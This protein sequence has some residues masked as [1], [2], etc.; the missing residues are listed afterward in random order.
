[1]KIFLD[2][3][4][5]EEAEELYNTGVCDGI[6]MNPSLV[7]KVVDQNKKVKMEDYIKKILKLAKGTPVSLEVT[8]TDCKEMVRQGKNIFKIFN[9]TAR[10]VYVKIPINP[11]YGEE[12]G[13]ETDGIK[14]IRDLSKAGIPVNCTLIFTPEQALLAAK[15]GAAFVSPFAGRIDDFIK[16]NHDVSFEKTDYFPAFGWYESDK[17]WEDNGVVSGIDLVRQIV[18]IFR[19]HNIHTE[20]LAASMRNARQVREAALVGADI[21]T[22]PFKIFKN[23]L[24]HYKTREGMEKFTKDAPKEYNKLIS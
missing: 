24:E 13:K 3:A 19:Q 16:K 6:T 23:L 4:I 1:M 15:A 22:L 14:A 21:A 10:N 20:I 17:C 11:S 12:E 7:K 18:E 9:P 5:Y 8:A 2:S